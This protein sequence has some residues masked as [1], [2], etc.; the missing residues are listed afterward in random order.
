VVVLWDFCVLSGVVPVP[1]LRP[2]PADHRL[3]RDNLLDDQGSI[4]RLDLWQ[5]K[6]VEPSSVE[7]D[8][9]PED[10]DDISIFI[11]Q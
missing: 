4:R 5:G 10:A 9:I 11:E 8:S 6:K 7:F 2:E 1:T 3:E